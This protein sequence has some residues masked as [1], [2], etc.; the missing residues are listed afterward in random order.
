MSKY[1]VGLYTPGGGYVKDN[2][3][4]DDIESY[5]REQENQGNKIIGIYE[6]K[7]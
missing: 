5:C 6:I 4:T 2:I 7:D 3:E 1:H